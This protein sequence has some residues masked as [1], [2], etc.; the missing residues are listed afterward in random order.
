MSKESRAKF[1]DDM[2]MLGFI[3]MHFNR[4]G[5]GYINKYLNYSWQA[6]QSAHARRQSEIDSLRAENERLIKE[7]AYTYNACRIVYKQAYLDGG[8]GYTA[9]KYAKN[10]RDVLESIENIAGQ[11]N[12]AN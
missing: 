4:R 10:A 1:E 9:F 2:K 5:D 11:N 8:E 6:Y 7:L 12:E 3:D